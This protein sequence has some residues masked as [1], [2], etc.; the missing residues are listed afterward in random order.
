VALA[1]NL[2]INHGK[3]LAGGELPSALVAREAGE[4]EDLIFRPTHPVGRRD[5][6]TALGAFCSKGSENTRIGR[7]VSIQSS[8]MTSSVFD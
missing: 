2:L 1:E 4:V 3:L 6:S 8:S 7:T 5:A